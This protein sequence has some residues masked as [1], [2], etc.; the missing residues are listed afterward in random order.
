MKNVLNIVRMLITGILVI[1]SIPLAITW[2]TGIERQNE[3][4]V[5]LHVISGILFILVAI[6]I[7]VREKRQQQKQ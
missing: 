5:I 7:T 2:L 1:T 6:P 4:M 3:F